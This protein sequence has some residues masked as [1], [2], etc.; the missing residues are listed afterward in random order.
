MK[1]NKAA[2]VGAGYGLL[3]A[4]IFL[5]INLFSCGGPLSMIGGML[6]FPA[7]VVGGGLSMLLLSLGLG[8]HGDA[9]FGVVVIA[10]VVSTVIQWVV[11]G[12]I[13][14]LFIGKRKKKCNTSAK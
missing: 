12:M 14:G 9:G 7:Y 11:I 6:C 1:F 5:C 2:I 3:A 8:P 4:I 10:I 13:V